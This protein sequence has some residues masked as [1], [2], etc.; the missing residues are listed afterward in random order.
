MGPAGQ[1]PELPA[2]GDVAL[3]AA[4]RTAYWSRKKWKDCRLG[5]QAMEVPPSTKNRLKAHFNL[6]AS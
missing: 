6:C 3:G 2:T 4:T 5:V 1:I